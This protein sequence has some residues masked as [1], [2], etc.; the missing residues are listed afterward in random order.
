MFF[1]VDN[2]QLHFTNNEKASNIFEDFLSSAAPASSAF[3]RVLDELESYLSTGPESLNFQDKMMSPLEWWFNHRDVYPRLSRMARDYLSIPGKLP[4]LGN[5]D[6]NTR[7]MTSH[8][9]GCRTCIFEGPP[10][11]ELFTEPPGCT[12]HT[13]YLVSQ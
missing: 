5:Y 1:E 3:A 2:P 9:C 8:L 4:Y 7:L 12:D 10:S 6:V 13:V 11:S